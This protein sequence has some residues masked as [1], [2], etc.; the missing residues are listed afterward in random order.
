MGKMLIRPA[1]INAD[2]EDFLKHLIG[3]G[4]VR[5]FSEVGIARLGS[6][7]SGE[8]IPSLD[9]RC[10]QMGDKR[11]FVGVGWTDEWKA[12]P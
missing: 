5:R 2:E 9:S 12:E 7:C 8:I 6:D 4:L 3:I 11:V 10:F 1:R